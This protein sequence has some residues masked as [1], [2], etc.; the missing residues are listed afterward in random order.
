MGEKERQDFKTQDAREETGEE[1][2]YVVE[3]KEGS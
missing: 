3:E 1:V 2:S